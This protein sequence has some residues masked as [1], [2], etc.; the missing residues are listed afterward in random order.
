MALF[1]QGVADLL[2]RCLAMMKP[3]LF[4]GGHMTVKEISE[5]TS[6]SEKKVK[7]YVKLTGDFFPM[8]DKN[9]YS[10]EQILDEYYIQQTKYFN[11][12]IYTE[13]LLNRIE[14]LE[15]KLSDNNIEINN[16]NND[17]IAKEGFV[18]II[19]DNSKENCYKIGKT[20]YLTNRLKSLQTGNPYIEIIATLKTYDFNKIEK[21]LHKKL[22]SKRIKNEWF[23]IEK[24]LLKFIIN[25]YK[26]NLFL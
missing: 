13:N 1:L 24:N 9:I 26:F 10:S 16:K 21:E 7:E 17:N 15:K 2:C 5:L 18:Y 6:L 22:K 8:S 11:L 4:Y 12:Y 3:F 19:K 25:N 23:E 14:F 20:L